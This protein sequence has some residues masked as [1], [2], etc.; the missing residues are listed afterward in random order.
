MPG[1]TPV[2]GLR[3]GEARGR[4]CR[5]VQHPLR[6]RRGAGGKWSQSQQPGQPRLLCSRRRRR[7][8]HER[9]GSGRIC[10]SS[11]P[12]PRCFLRALWPLLRQRLPAPGG[13]RMGEETERGS[14]TCWVTR[15]LLPRSQTA[16]P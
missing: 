1:P 8:S 4:C 13:A 16:R 15:G 9:T 14:D 10:P 7:A 5:T 11:G 12:E 3:G 6:Y 2:T